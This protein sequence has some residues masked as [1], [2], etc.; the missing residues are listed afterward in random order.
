MRES[1]FKP[2]CEP[3]T[4]LGK[5]YRKKN[6]ISNQSKAYDGFAEAY[7]VNNAILQDIQELYGKVNSIKN[8]DALDRAII[9]MQ[10]GLQ[11]MQYKA[12]RMGIELEKGVNSM[13]NRADEKKVII[14]DIKTA[15][16]LIDNLKKQLTT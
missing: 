5:V 3:L 6:M 12:A 7:R 14:E 15:T 16:F 10:K 9:N 11:K 2:N 1:R 13:D 4:P 8:T